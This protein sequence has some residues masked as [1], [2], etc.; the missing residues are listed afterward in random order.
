MVRPALALA[1]LVALLPSAPAR[2]LPAAPPASG[3]GASDPLAERFAA[4]SAAAWRDR[5]S[6][7]ALAQLLTLEALEA[8]HPDLG[9]LAAVYA[10]LEGDGGTHPEVR[11]AARFRLSRVERAQGNLL[12]S[13]S[14]LR[15]LGFVAGWQVI[16][17]FDDEG[18]RGFAAVYP[19]EEAVDAAARHPGKER[20]VA[21]RAVPKEAQTGG[22]VHLGATLRPAREVVAYALTSVV[23]DRE[24]RVQLW[25]GASGAA[26]VWVNGALALEDPT[27]HEARLDQRGATVTLRKGAN[28]ILVKLCQQDGRMGFHLRLADARGEGRSFTVGDAFAP[29]ASPGPAPAP[30][31]DAVEVLARRA[32]AARGKAAPVAH[33]TLAAVLRARGADDENDRRAAAEAAKAAALAP[34]DVDAQLAA[35]S[36]EEDR[37]RRRVFLDAAHRI[38]PEDPRVLRLLADE[39]LAHE[40]P[41]AAARLLVRAIAAAPRWAEL[42]TTY[43]EAL[44]RSGLSARAALVAEEAARHFPTSPAAVRGAAHAAMRLGRL[45]QVIQRERTLLALRFDDLGVRASLASHLLDRGDLDGAAG[46]LREGLRVAPGE[47]ALQLR[48]ADLLAANERMEE[49]EEAYARALDLCPEDA[50]AWERR[51]RARLSA[52]RAR[53]AQADLARALA[54]KPQNPALKELVRSLTPDEE[55]FWKPYQLDARALAAKAPPARP[56]EDAIVLGELHVTRVL[57]T[58]LSS[59]YTHRVVKILTRRGADAFRRQSLA[60][61]PDRQELRV[62]R[63][64]VL[65]PDGRT[66]ESHG[67]SVSSAS[68]PWYR[69]YYDLMARNLSFE[70]LQPGDVLEVAWRVDDTASEN[71]LSDYFGDVTFVDETSR[72]LRFEYVLLVPEA[73]AIYANA[74]A[75]VE[76]A[77]RALPG[78]VREHRYSARDLPR[79]VPEPGMPG[80]SEV[81]RYLHVSTYRTWDE[82]NQFYWRLVRDQL[83]PTPEIQG[84]A[85][86]LAAAA[87]AGK[88]TAIPAKA[89][90]SGGAGGGACPEAS[91]GSGGARTSCPPGKIT[92]LVQAAYGFVVSQTRYV[93]LEFGIH[94]YKPYRVDQVLARRFGDCKDKA[95]LL[96]A[97]LGSMGIESR[98]VLLRMRRL[99]RIP[100]QPASLAVFNHAIVYVPELDLWLDGTAAYSGTRDLPAEDRGATVLVVNPDGPPRFTTIPEAGAGDNRL[101]AELDLALAPDGSAV[102]RGLW[103]A[104][105]QAAPDF[106]RTYGPEEGRRKILEQTL[107]RLFPGA[108]VEGVT[109]SDLG[110][111]EDDVELRFSASVPRAAQADGAGLRFTP[112][113][114]AQGY[115]ESYASLATRTHELDLGAP[116]DTRF[117]YRYTL[118]AGWRVVDLP[119]P[120][121]GETPLGRFE[122]RFQEERG[123]IVAEGRIALPG[124]RVKVAEYPSFRELMIQLDRAFSRRVRIAPAV[125]K[126]HR[127]AAATGSVS[128]WE[129]TAARETPTMEATP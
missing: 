126:D 82:V 116:R 98:I 122:L 125:Q 105:G 68:E 33:A 61:T 17:P 43:A 113:G 75:G 87:T 23:A 90:A 86:Q 115:A 99:G 5:A 57:P 46:L 89:E 88:G 27:Y 26:K 50:D 51:G 100:E 18:K 9:R 67:E 3:P 71:L 73:R 13:E 83:K 107:S 40:R 25:F 38:A 49:A 80:W 119:A 63:A 44:E 10:S 21:W 64:A 91:G 129:V 76:H 55:R 96:H 97:L 6:P 123:A 81:A 120:A 39:E 121:H 124:A 94:G 11:A 72:K 106:R 79:V 31:E 29:A 109:A 15:T 112:F 93:G 22:F 92:S 37:T 28:R 101:E 45:E 118:P 70:A 102:V 30:I 1:A 54:L 65:K 127:G 104:A 41:Q 36:L 58:G 53:E 8:E 35:A 47:L 103:R 2:G 78:G 14:R 110:R 24:G 7:S 117:R 84:L 56:D 114:A 12:R 111:I 85:R 69:L 59:S 77:V 20:E 66:V 62:E 42:R 74:P 4:A 52:G 108:K 32:A 128:P 16:G 60:W 19:P 34:R 95:S 48:L